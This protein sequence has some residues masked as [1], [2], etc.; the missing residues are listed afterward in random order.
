MFMVILPNTE[1]YGLILIILLLLHS[2]MNCS[3]NWNKAYYVTLNLL[4][5]FLAKCQYSFT[6]VIQYKSRKS[7]LFTANNYGRC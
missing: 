7:R 3:R 2:D 1:Y 5:R 4:L 6:A